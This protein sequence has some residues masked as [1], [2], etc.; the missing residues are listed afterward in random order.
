MKMD[1][2]PSIGGLLD[3]SFPRTRESRFVLRRISLDTRFRGYDGAPEA[4]RCAH[5]PLICFFEGGT[6]S[7][8][9]GILII[10]T[11]GSF[12]SLSVIVCSVLAN[13]RKTHRRD[14]ENAE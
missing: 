11:C 9:F 7:T 8:K 1:G 5:H 4:L 12:V 10:E 13:F 6:K 14:A 3:A 2:I